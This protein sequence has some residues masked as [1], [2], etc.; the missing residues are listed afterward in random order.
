MNYVQPIRDQNIV[1]DIG[2]YLKKQSERNYIM[3]LCGIYTGL[4]ISDI[5]NLRI[6]DVKNKNYINIREKKTGKQKV[7]EINPIL[8]KELKYYL[9]DKK[10]INDYL[11]QSRE[12]Y[13][14]PLSRSMAYKILREA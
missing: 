10:E 4:R 11:I 6:T 2:A 5:L 8:K 12:G 3:Y 14:Q 1:R 13:N 9:E 7:V